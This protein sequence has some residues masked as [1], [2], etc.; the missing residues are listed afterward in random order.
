MAGG[1]EEP[2]APLWRESERVCGG[3][4]EAGGGAGCSCCCCR[5]RARGAWRGGGRGAPELGEHRRGSL[6]SPP[7]AAPGSLGAAAGRR[8]G[9][10][11]GRGH[12]HLMEGDAE[13]RTSGLDAIVAEFDS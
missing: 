10:R 8:A 1:G 13:F 11:A 5:A 3:E 2:Q 9:R 7:F 4:E 12:L 6:P